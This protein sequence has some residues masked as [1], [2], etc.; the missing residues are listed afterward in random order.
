MKRLFLNG[1]SLFTVPEIKKPGEVRK[2]FG[3]PKGRESAEEKKETPPRVS[4]LRDSSY[5]SDQ[6]LGLAALFLPLG[7]LLRWQKRR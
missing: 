7:L 3:E 6:M 4:E 1:G 2:Y 5:G